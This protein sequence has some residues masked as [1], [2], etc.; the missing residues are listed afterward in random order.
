VAV[1][2]SSARAAGLVS[3]ARL[4]GPGFVRVFP[5]VYVPASTGAPGL[6]L[7]S[8]AAYRLVEGHG[9]LSGY[10][11]ALL[12]GADC[13]PDPDISAEVTVPG[14]RQ[15][16]HPGLWVHRD[17]LAAGEIVNV[18]G[19]RCTSPLRTAYDLARR[20]D[21]VEAVVAVD[22]LA[23]THRFH[24]DLLLHFAVHYRG[25][26]GNDR[27]PDVL[28]AASPYAGSP[29]ETRLRLVIINGGLPR[30]RVQWPVQDEQRRTVIWL[31]LAYPELGIGIEYEGEE[32]TAPERVLRDI[33]RYTRL[34]DHGWRIYGYTKHEVYREPERIVA[35]LA[36]A[37]R[38]PSGVGRAEHGGGPE[39]IR[40]P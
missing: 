28:A 10:S 40:Q 13:A 15:R 36:R 26:R 19:L 9:V 20:P 2:G 11:A 37:R 14:G 7:R 22:G 4:R 18:G 8:A 32:H 17:R 30:P 6:A 35:E 34:V 24:P 33:S 12:L 31:D 25:A 29:M 38:R 23:N 27:V 5:D 1:R 21:R 39:R 3:W 16:P